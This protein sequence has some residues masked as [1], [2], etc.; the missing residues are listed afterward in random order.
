MAAI[1]Q[2]LKRSTSKGLPLFIPILYGGNCSREVCNLVLDTIIYFSLAPR[3][4]RLILDTHSCDLN[5]ISYLLPSQVPQLKSLIFRNEAVIKNFDMTYSISVSWSAG[6]IVKAP[7]LQEISFHQMT[8][9]IIELPLRWSQMTRISLGSIAG[10]RMFS[11]PTILSLSVE[12]SCLRPQVLQVTCAVSIGAPLTGR[13]PQ[14]N[15]IVSHPSK[16]SPFTT[17]ESM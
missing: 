2:W 14:S 5:R 16:N 4:N 3:W 11:T 15:Q 7:K 10:L 8:D 13:K 17:A 1:H 6:V 12:A 9:N